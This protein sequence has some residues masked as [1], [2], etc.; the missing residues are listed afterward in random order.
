MAAKRNFSRWLSH[1]VA[2][3]LGTA[4]TLVA[5]SGHGIVINE[6]SVVATNRKSKK[7]VA[8]GADAKKMVGRTPRA[9]IAARPLVDGVVSDFEITEHMLRRFVERLHHEHRVLIRRPRMMVGLPSGVTEVEKRAVEEAARSAGARRI[10]LIE[11]PVAA[12]IGSG[13]DIEKEAG[14]MVVDIGGGTTEIAILASGQVL[15]TK[16]IRIAGDELTDSMMILMRDEYNLQIGERTAEAM[17]Q[18]IG[19]VHGKSGDKTM[20]VR[21]RNIITGLPQQI[22]ISSENVR[23]AMSRQVRPIIDTI[24]SVIDE[25]PPEILSDIMQNGVHV[26]GGG[27]LIAGIDSL[28]QAETKISATVPKNAL[29]A[30]VE[31]ATIALED[32]DRYHHVLTMS[33]S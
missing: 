32:V 3:D 8:V 7:V 10:Y 1:D 6:P 20:T 28:I 26:A 15:L 2:V 16:S 23:Q 11:E 30:V 18:T 5:V 9:I 22:D 27:G 14:S 31:G 4:N 21:G 29:T 13:V 33:Q 24:R 17:K 12:A 25:T 19:S